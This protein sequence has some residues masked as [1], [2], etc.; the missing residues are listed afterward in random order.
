MGS[1]LSIFY[2]FCYEQ[3]THDGY[4][5]IQTES[6]DTNS[7]QSSP[8]FFSSPCSNVSN[9]SSNRVNDDFELHE[10]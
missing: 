7:N 2:T 4:K 10:S 9:T 8:R 3:N 1:C 5:P 6:I